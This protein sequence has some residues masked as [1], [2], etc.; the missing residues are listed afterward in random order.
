MK[1][2]LSAIGILTLTAAVFTGC[3]KSNNNTSNN[4]GSESQSQTTTQTSEQTTTSIPETSGVGD[5]DGDG[6]VEDIITDAGDVVDDVVTG[7]EDIVDDILPGDA[8]GNEN[9]ANGNNGRSR[10]NS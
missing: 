4:G 8:N 1:K 10:T 2:L 3:G 7:A 5:I 6:I 9:S